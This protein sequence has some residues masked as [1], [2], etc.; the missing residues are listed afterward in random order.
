MAG[1]VGEGLQIQMSG[2]RYT[3]SRDPFSRDISTTKVAQLKI[4]LGA[5]LQCPQVEVSTS[6][7]LVPIAAAAASAA[8]PDSCLLSAT[9]AASA[10]GSRVRGLLLLLLLFLLLIVVLDWESQK[11]ICDLSLT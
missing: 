2:Y 9:A 11:F 8:A 10:G 7:L 5:A 4:V 1:W 3:V 6:F